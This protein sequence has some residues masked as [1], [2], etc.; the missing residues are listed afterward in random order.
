M[1]KKKYPVIGITSNIDYINRG[2][3]KSKQ[4]I[5]P[6]EYIDIVTSAN[7]IP[8]IISSKIDPKKHIGQ[9]S[10]M[11]DGLIL[12]GGQDIASELY[13]EKSEITYSNNTKSILGEPFQ[14]PEILKPEVAKD[15]FEVELYH[16]VKEKGIPILGICRGMQIINVAEGGSLYQELTEV[17]KIDHFISEQI[18][19]PYHSLLIKPKSKFHRLLGKTEYFTS[20]IHHQAVKTL[21]EDI[22][23]SGHS[24]DNIIELIE[25]KDSSRFI[26]GIQGHAELT[27]KNLNLYKNVFDD[28]FEHC[29]DQC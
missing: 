29:L 2:P 8:Y 26:L 14:R 17:E 19:T 6:Y 22:I 28:F 16:T 13:G 23:A 12:I 9:L 15:I 24:E 3:F 7:C 5:L 20:S 1:M 25:H 11:L 18:V 27:L 21:G 10:D 4:T